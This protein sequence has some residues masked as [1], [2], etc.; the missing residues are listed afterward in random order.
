MSVMVQTP[1]GW[2]VDSCS[3]ID[4]GCSCCIRFKDNQKSR[5][6][7]HFKRQ[8]FN[9]SKSHCNETACAA[10]N[11][12]HTGVLQKTEK[13]SKVNSAEFHY[14]SSRENCEVSL[15]EIKKTT[16]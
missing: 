4:Q 6:K 9:I 7:Y 1:K 11:G 15:I 2:F 16:V 5:V 10:V 14:R 8:C 13:P 3:L 12:G